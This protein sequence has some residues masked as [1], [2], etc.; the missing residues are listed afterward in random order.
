MITTD[1]PA[2]PV[3]FSEQSPI[4]GANRKRVR[5]SAQ[6]REALLAEWRSSGLSA[7]AFARERAISYSTFAN[8]RRQEARRKAATQGGAIRFAEVVARESGSAGIEVQLDAGALIKI[9]HPAQAV[10]AAA[11]IRAL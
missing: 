4:T 3:Q 1:T 6:R 9:D 11:L 5:V 7:A 8:W 2:P 10:L